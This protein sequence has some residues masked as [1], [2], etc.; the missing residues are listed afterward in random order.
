MICKTLHRK[1]KIAQQ[2]LHKTT[3]NSAVR[4]CLYHAV[5]VYPHFQH[6]LGYILMNRILRGGKPPGRLLPTLSLETVTCG[7]Y[8]VYV[9]CGL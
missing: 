9:N 5:G 1:L 2:E 3:G 8:G 7:E 4:V 6:L